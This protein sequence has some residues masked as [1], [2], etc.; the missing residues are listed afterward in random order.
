MDLFG[1]E[2]V[3]RINA[4]DWPAEFPKIFS[5]RPRSGRGAGGEGKNSGFD[6]VIG[7]P[8]YGAIFGENEVQ[9]LLGKFDP[10]QKTPDAYV[11][12]LE[13]AHA[14][15]LKRG[16][17]GFIIPSAWLGGPSYKKLREFVLGSQIDSV[18]LLPFDVF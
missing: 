3:Y 2:E 5:P 6:A 7:N 18:V 4:F 15:L 8:P 11:A 17:F 10:F 14:L 13:Q 16:K 1:E 12:F 9:Y